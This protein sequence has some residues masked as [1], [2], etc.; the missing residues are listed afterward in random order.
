MVKKAC[1]S[2]T[3]DSKPAL[4]T[5]QENY[6]YSQNTSTGALGFVSTLTLTLTRVCPP[7]SFVLEKKSLLLCF[8]KKR[9]DLKKMFWHKLNLCWILWRDVIVFAVN[10]TGVQQSLWVCLTAVNVLKSFSLT[11]EWTCYSS[12]NDSFAIQPGSVQHQLVDL[13]VC[14]KTCWSWT[15]TRSRPSVTVSVST[16]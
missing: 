16:H 5:S 10:I 8:V 15:P 12:G 2:D 6:T 3:F 14:L 4:S 1:D 11:C 13:N 7:P 9:F